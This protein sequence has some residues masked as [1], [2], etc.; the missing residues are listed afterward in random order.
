MQYYKEN[1]SNGF[2][3]E[4]IRFG[5]IVKRLENCSRIILEYCDGKLDRI[6]E[7]DQKVVD[8]LTGEDEHVKGAFT[9]NGYCDES[10]VLTL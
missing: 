10:S 2:E 5:G 8:Y 4:D 3:I 9:E 1:K 6:E 7:L